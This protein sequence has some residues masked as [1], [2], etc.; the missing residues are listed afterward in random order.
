MF[1]SA[2][3]DSLLLSAVEAC[4]SSSPITHRW[5]HEYDGTRWAREEEERL[6]REEEERQLKADEAVKQ[7]MAERERAREAGKQLRMAQ[8]DADIGESTRRVI[9][10]PGVCC[11]EDRCFC[12][13]TTRGR[14]I[15]LP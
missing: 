6:K 8:E 4:L 7:A 10:R 2:L 1:F 11:N 3:V 5:T 14:R 9:G 15:A 12:F 13:G